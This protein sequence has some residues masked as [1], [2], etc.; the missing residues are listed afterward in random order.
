M[1]ITDTRQFFLTV[2][3]F[4][5]EF[6]KK[7]CTQLKYVIVRLEKLLSAYFI[8]KFSLSCSR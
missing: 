4:Y 6:L 8:I 2:S 1:S 5:I 3:I 7:L